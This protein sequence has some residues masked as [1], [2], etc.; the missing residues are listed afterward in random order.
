MKSRF[1]KIFF[2]PKHWNIVCKMLI[3]HLYF[4]A[5]QS[6]YG[7]NSILKYKAIQA[8]KAAGT[9]NKED[10]RKDGEEAVVEEPTEELVENDYGHP[11]PL[12]AVKRTRRW[13]WKHTKL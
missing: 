11:M 1:H 6:T 9:N 12:G 10:I 13:G 8:P 3:C 5:E 7:I 4:I 2:K